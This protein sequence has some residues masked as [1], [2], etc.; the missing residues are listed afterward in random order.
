VK[1]ERQCKRGRERLQLKQQQ[2]DLQRTFG[3]WR[4]SWRT[5]DKTEAPKGSLRRGPPSSEEEGSFRPHH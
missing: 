3:S 1:R 4:I 5:S 2:E